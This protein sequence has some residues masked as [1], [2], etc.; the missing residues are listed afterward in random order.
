LRA[1]HSAIADGLTNPEDEKMKLQN[2]RV[3]TRLGAGFGLVALL[4]GVVIVLALSSMRQIQDGM[5][6]ITQVNDVE[7]QLAATMEQTVTERALALRNLILLTEQ[8]EIQIE[9]ERI[10]AQEQRYAEAQQRLGRLFGG[11]ADTT[12]EEHTLLARIRQQAELA[13]PFVRQAAAL[14]LDKKTDDAYRLLRYD[15][16]PVQR[17]WWDLLRELRALEERQ[18]TAAVAAAAQTYA[19]AR[20]LVS[21]FGVLALAASVAAALLITR[22]VVR[23][24]GCEPQEAVAIAAQ[25]AAGNLATAI[26]PRPGDQSSL[27]F[28]MRAMRDSLTDIV[29]RVRSS[30][31]TLSVSAGQLAGGNSDLSARTEQQA[32]ALEQT[33]ASMEQLTSAVQHNADNAR[34][35]NG[36]VS[37]ASAIATQGGTVVAQVVDTMAAIDASA[38]K[39]VDI[40]AVIDGI[41]FQTNILALNAAVEAAR[42][43]EQGRGFAVVASEVRNLAQRSAAAAREIKGLI[44][45]SVDKVQQGNQLVDE[46]GATMHN[47]V[48]SVRQVADIM[49]EIMAASQEQSQG[50]AQ[51]NAAIVQMD[52][53]TQQ[54]AALVEEATAATESMHELATLLSDAVGVFH[55]DAQGESPRAGREPGAAATPRLSWQGAAA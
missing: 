29:C 1:A 35:A 42:A 6:Q 21:G 40:I 15:F 8:K 49:A 22:S 20:W 2:M 13:T 16:R 19:R 54:N 11:T 34:Q 23:Q 33:A 14:A 18:N 53:V 36:L 37:S 5:D 10:A 48:A 55:L 4:L 7:A 46:A 3:A 32:S 50:I 43:G 39:I 26:A 12:A 38:R 9:V 27:L 51:V 45:D 25:I 24:L 30:T 47:V 28:A 31:D 44:G 17:K 41:A 52:S